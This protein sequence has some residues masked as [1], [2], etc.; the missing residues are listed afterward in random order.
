MEPVARTGSSASPPPCHALRVP[1]IWCDVRP[2]GDKHVLLAWLGP[3]LAAHTAS[4]CLTGGLCLADFGGLGLAQLVDVADSGSADFGGLW[5]GAAS[6]G[7]AGGAWQ[8]AS[9]PT[10][11]PGLSVS[12]SVSESVSQ[13]ISQL[14]S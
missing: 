9:S 11:R 13:A 4:L 3:L 2:C 12:Q 5:A 10:H 8:S 14:V 6:V 7:P 1:T